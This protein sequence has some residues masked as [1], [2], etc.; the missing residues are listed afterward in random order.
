M[1]L[2]FS[3][4]YGGKQQLG[5][6]HAFTVTRVLRIAAKNSASKGTVSRNFRYLTISTELISKIEIIETLHPQLHINLNFVNV[7][8]HKS[9]KAEDKI[10]EQE[11]RLTTGCPMTNLPVA[12]TVTKIHFEV[13]MGG[14]LVGREQNYSKHR[15]ANLHFVD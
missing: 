8:S 13:D 11:P 14:Q 4:R 2:K 10:N 7:N 9:Q 3:G 12:T 5:R 15:S 1:E 6:M